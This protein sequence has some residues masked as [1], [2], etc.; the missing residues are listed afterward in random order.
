MVVTSADAAQTGSA[1][2]NG[3]IDGPIDAI[4]HN[5]RQ[6]P[7]WDEHVRRGPGGDFYVSYKPINTDGYFEVYDAYNNLIDPSNYTVTPA[8]GK[9][10]IATD[11]TA[12]G[13][14]FISYEANLFPASDLYQLMIATMYEIN[15]IVPD[16]GHQVTSYNGIDEVPATFDGALVAGTVTKAFGRLLSD[17]GL[18]LD[19]YIWADAEAGKSQAQSQ[20]DWYKDLFIRLAEGAK[21]QAALA[22][23]TPA[24]TAFSSFGLGFYGP[25]GLTGKWRGM[26]V[27]RISSYGMM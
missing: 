12:S 3:L 26:R 1:K 23:P 24:Y 11:D 13:D 9:I 16:G 25:N 5:F 2:A 6:L 10:T 8:A 22:L 14:Y 19:S 17:S 27:N 18:W 15:G 7:L 21:R 20:I 4:L